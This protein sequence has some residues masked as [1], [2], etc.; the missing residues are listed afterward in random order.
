MK[1]CHRC[2][3]TGMREAKG[4]IVT[5]STCKGTG[6]VKDA[7]EVNAEL[8]KK[9]DE[10]MAAA[11][12]DVDLV[13][14]IININNKKKSVKKSEPPK[15]PLKPCKHKKLHFEDGGLHIVCDDCSQAWQALNKQRLVPEFM[16]R[17][18]GFSKL[19]VRKDPLS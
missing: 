5:C 1:K 10:E 18:W 9:R 6:Q 13:Q 8:Q 15:K 7:R 19:D 4:D 14:A 16:A 11:K 3:G 17:G 2:N 12:T